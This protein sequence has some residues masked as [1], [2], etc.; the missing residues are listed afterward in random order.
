MARL[1][2]PQDAVLDV[3]ERVKRRVDVVLAV[4]ASCKEGG[5]GWGGG[6]KLATKKTQQRAQPSRSMKPPTPCDTPKRT[7]PVVVKRVSGH[8]RVGV[9]VDN[10]GVDH[11]RVVDIDPER[12][13]AVG[14][15]RQR[16]NP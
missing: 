15:Q 2:G 1:V 4:G 9:A 10:L 7:A 13:P 3:V 14:V 16:V 6:I 5:R 12:Q 8:G 11:N